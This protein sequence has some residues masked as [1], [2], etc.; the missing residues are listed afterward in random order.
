M[1]SKKNKV[2][3]FGFRTASGWLITGCEGTINYKL[4][5]A[6]KISINTWNM[7]WV[8]WDSFYVCKKI[9]NF[10]NLLNGQVHAFFFPIMSSFVIRKK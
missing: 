4:E 9:G 6:S 1:W 2:A 8:A 10:Y 5:R 7:E 3:K